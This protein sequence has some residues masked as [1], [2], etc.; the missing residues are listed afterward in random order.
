MLGRRSRRHGG[1]LTRRPQLHQVPGLVGLASSV[2]LS[3]QL[4]SGQWHC[5]AETAAAADRAEIH[6]AHGASSCGHHGHL[7]AAVGCDAAKPNR[8]REYPNLE[9][10]SIRAFQVVA[11][12]CGFG[13][14]NGVTTLFRGDEAALE[15]AHQREAEL[16]AQLQVWSSRGAA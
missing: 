7:A 13:V 8:H 15:A 11:E 5:V 10:N 1:T 12:Q 9:R 3:L 6:L 14:L 2:V 16:T 4:K